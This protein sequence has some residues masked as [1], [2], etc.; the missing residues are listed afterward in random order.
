[1]E[2]NKVG[3]YLPGFSAHYYLKRAIQDVSEGDQDERAK[4]GTVP[5]VPMGKLLGHM[6]YGTLFFGL[7]LGYGLIVIET[8][9]LNPFEQIGIVRKLQDNDKKKQ[10]LSDLEKEIRYQYNEEFY[11]LRE[12]N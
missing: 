6:L 5:M 7:V 2:F 12:K 9:K 1:M 8:G 3:K 11:K 4:H 10:S